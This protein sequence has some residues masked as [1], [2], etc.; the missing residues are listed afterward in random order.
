MP[1][2]REGAPNTAATPGRTCAVEDVAGQQHHI[3]DQEDGRVGGEVAADDG[4]VHHEAPELV[5]E[6]LRKPVP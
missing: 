5:V 4:L 2:M 6:H 3:G 1:V